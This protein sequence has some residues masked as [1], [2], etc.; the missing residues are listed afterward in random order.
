MFISDSLPFVK[1]YIEE[2]DVAVK[3]Y[4][5]NAR[6]SRSQKAWLAFCI[7]AIFV[8]RTVCWAKFERACLGKHSTAALSWVFR[9]ATIPW[10]FL[11]TASTMIVIKR[12]GITRGRLAIDET[13]K[14]RS[15]SAKM[16]WVRLFC[17]T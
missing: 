5:E 15:K 11:L 4:D 16:I 1:R 10:N 9:K 6:L 12:F 7:M 13:D 8:T 17:D 3:Q 14:K 2:L